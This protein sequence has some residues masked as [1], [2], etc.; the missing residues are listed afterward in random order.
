MNRYADVRKQSGG[1]SLLP[2]ILVFALCFSVAPAY[3]VTNDHVVSFLVGPL[4]GYGSRAETYSWSFSYME[5]FG[6]GWAW[7]L[8]KLNEGHD[9]DHHRDG[10]TLQL[11]K[12]MGLL[13]GDRLILGLGLGPHFYCD[14]L[15][16]EDYE[17]GYENDHGPGLVLSAMARYRLTDN[18]WLESRFNT[19]RNRDKINTGSIMLGAACTLEP[20]WSGGH[21]REVNVHVNE[22]TLLGGANIVNSFGSET[23][24]AFSFEYRRYMFSWLNA[25]VV[26]LAENTPDYVERHGVAPQL[27]WGRFFCK[28]H[29][30]MG[31]GAGPYFAYDRQRSSQ[32]HLSDQSNFDVSLL[33]SYTAAYHFDHGVL[34]RA[35]WHRV[36]TAYDYNRDTD[37]ILLGAGY[38]F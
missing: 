5:G 7:S 17:Q 26:Y 11:W 32:P 10:T 6:D 19:A 31:F 4:T 20:A 25:T 30:S 35:T 3:S 2:T 24:S 13:S 22:V 21:A 1:G 29:L 16:S 33:A 36:A 18:W 23:G 12:R 34:L 38:G 8:S 37:V 15:T 27:Y 28:G 9:E 14:T